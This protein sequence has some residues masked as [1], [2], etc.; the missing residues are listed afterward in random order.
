MCH[1][2]ALQGSLCCRVYGQ[3][4]TASLDGVGAGGP[5]GLQQTSTDGSG[6][7]RQ[8]ADGVRGRVRL[9]VRGGLGRCR[10]GRA[11]RCDLSWLRLVRTSAPVGD[12]LEGL[13]EVVGDGIGG[14]DGLPSG[15]DLDREVAAGG[16]DEFPD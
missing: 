5:S 11:C 16:L 7:D 15:L 9:D 6:G 12:G 14:G 3:Q 1:L 4:R 2:V 10:C 13:A 8:A